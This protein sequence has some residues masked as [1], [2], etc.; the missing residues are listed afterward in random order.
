MPVS[1]NEVI[2]A[3][4]FILGREPESEDAVTQHMSKNDS[5][6]TLR[7]SFLRSA[8]FIGQRSGPTSKPVAHSFLP[9][10]L[11]KNEIEHVA[12]STQLAQCIAKIK[13]A[14]SHMGITKPHFSVLTNN[15][16]LPENLDKNLDQFWASG[17]SEASLLERVL[18]KHGFGQSSGKVCVEYGCGVGRVTVGLAQKFSVVHGYDISEGHLAQAKRHASEVGAINCNFHLCSENVLDDLEKCDLFYS[19]I[20]FQ[21]NPP[22]IIRELVKIA[23]RSLRAGGIAIFQVPTYKAG[24]HFS[25]KE[26]LNTEHAL[27]M[28]MHCLPQSVIHALIA[29]NKCNLLE[30][31]EDNSTGAPDK[32]LS[33]TFV[34]RKQ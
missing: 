15:A 26:W 3:Y 22:P 6:A 12:T 30:V 16:Y 28:Q 9:L 17:L 20:V 10:D 2:S 7:E 13:A 11:A 21:H 33:N 4:R 18:L 25:I 34:V 32:Y 8:E 29:E 27:D 14:W 24:Y 31:R 1:K 19:R 5:V 23:L